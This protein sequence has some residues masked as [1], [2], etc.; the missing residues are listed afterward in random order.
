MAED[1]T[2]A[3]AT[4]EKTEAEEK[5]E[6]EEATTGKDAEGLREELRK[7]DRVRKRESAAAKKRIAD[8][9]AQLKEREDADKSEQEKAIEKARAD[10]RAEALREAD[11]QRRSDRLEVAITRQA[12]R[13]FADTD[14]ALLHIQR[15]IAAGEI[16]GDELFDDEGKV[17][18]DP[19][20]SA[21]GQLLEDKP[22]LAADD[23]RPKGSAD[24]GRGSGADTSAEDMS[25][26]DHFQTIRR[27]K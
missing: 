10:A 19:L 17:R 1:T 6:A 20:K 12:A 4:E 24:G 13:S 22:H 18:A 7:G 21:L 14:D 16:D 27:R 23:G 11:A 25:V 26:E 5:P 8:L 9:E 15:R 3:E 2:T